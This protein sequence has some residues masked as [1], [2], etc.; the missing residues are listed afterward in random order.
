LIDDAFGDIAA[1]DPLVDLAGHTGVALYV[2][3]PVAGLYVSQGKTVEVKANDLDLAVFAKA[4]P[5]LGRLPGPYRRSGH[6]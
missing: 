4:D 1:L 2:S 5:G 6:R 3:V